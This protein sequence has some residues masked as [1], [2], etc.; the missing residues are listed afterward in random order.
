MEQNLPAAERDVLACLHRHREA[1]SR[2]VLES[3]APFRPMAHG[4]VVTLLRRL[5][6][7]GLI[8]K[9]KGPVGKALLYRSRQQARITFGRAVRQ[10][11]QRVFHGDTTAAFATLLEANPPSLE[12]VEK[13]QQMLD[14]LKERRQRK[15]RK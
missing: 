12:E 2:E 7:K 4:S 1:T 9:R 14:Q 8:A 15:R 13:L 5:E 11:V 10:L 3:L 6:A